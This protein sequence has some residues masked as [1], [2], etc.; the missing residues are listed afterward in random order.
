MNPQTP[1]IDIIQPCY[2]PLPNWE[3]SVWLHFQNVLKLLPEYTV[4]LII[5]NDGSTKNV[6]EAQVDFLK[7]RIPNFTFINF[8]KNKGKGNALREGIKISTGKFQLYTDIDFPFE[9]MHI[10]EI[11]N[12]LDHGADI[13]SG[14][15]KQN[16]Y[17]TLSPQRWIASKASQ[18]LN[19]TFLN[20]PFNDTQS[21]IKG[22]NSNGKRVFLK[23]TINRYLADT[24]FLALAAKYK[25]T[26]HPLEV[27]LREDIV[28]SKMSLKTFMKE[29]DNFIR[30]YAII[31]KS[32][33]ES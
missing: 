10:K 17:Q 22:L 33:K 29:L 27:S 24:E 6:N 7:Q 9:L 4:N 30:I 15:R 16:Y 20:L 18:F 8:K 19:K 31:F 5:V 2:N 25:L 14:V 23:T 28:L 26:I 21:G 1:Q 12:W 32:S 13:V 3:Q 11:I